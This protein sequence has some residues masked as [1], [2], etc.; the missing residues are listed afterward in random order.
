MKQAYETL[1][2]QQILGNDDLDLTIH[3]HFQPERETR[4][5]NLP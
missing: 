1:F 5:Y 4:H 2:E 3:L